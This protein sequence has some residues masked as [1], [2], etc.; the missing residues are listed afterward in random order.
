M[1]N[2]ECWQIERYGDCLPEPEVTPSG[3]LESGVE[4]MERFT[5]WMELQHELQLHDYDKD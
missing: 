2:Y 1:T 5:E 4:S 3:E